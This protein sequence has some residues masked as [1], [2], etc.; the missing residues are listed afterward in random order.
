MLE[1]ECKE[2]L[3]C[4]ISNPDPHPGFCFLPSVSKYNENK[5]FVINIDSPCHPAH[6]LEIFNYKFWKFARKKNET[7]Q[8]VSDS[9]FLFF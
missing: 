6:V 2:R 8:I 9:F 5:K 7:M 3:E 4:G 1:G